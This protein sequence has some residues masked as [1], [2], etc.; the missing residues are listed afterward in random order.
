MHTQPSRRWP[1]GCSTV[2]ARRTSRTNITEVPIVRV[3]DDTIPR[4][5]LR[6]SG[7]NRGYG[8]ARARG[9]RP[10]GG[11]VSPAE[12]H[13]GRGVVVEE[14]GR[15]RVRE[16]AA[17]SISSAAGKVYRDIRRR[18]TTACATTL[19]SYIVRA[20]AKRFAFK[21]VPARRHH[22]RFGY[23]PARARGPIFFTPVFRLSRT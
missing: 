18:A 20:R 7:R 22:L 17:V 9:R 4:T 6:R 19:L 2:G 16:T 10:V 3:R 11:W 5:R 12:R 8:L 15:A 23:V 13:G 1:C 14:R 21:R